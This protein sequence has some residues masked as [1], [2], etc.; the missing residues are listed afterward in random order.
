M[1][2]CANPCEEQRKNAKATIGTRNYGDIGD[3][4]AKIDAVT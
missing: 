4:R 3:I 1:E 2:I